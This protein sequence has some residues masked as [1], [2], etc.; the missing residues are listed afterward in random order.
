MPTEI[1]IKINKNKSDNSDFAISPD[2][3]NGIELLKKQFDQISKETKKL[4]EIRNKLVSVLANHGWYLSADIDGQS[5]FKILSLIQNS[6]V[7][8]ATSILSKYYSKNLNKLKNNLTKK[9]PD[10]QS[11]FTEAFKAHKDKKYFSST[12]LFLSQADGICEGNM[13]R[14][15]KIFKEF[16]AKTKSPDMVEF[17]LGQES[18]IDVDTRK[19]D[20]SNYFSDLNRHGVMHGIHIDFGKEI[21]SLKAISLLCFISDFV[22]R[23]KQADKGTGG[24]SGLPQLA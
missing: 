9:H 23:Y 21:N 18:A 5:Y 14:R 11:I 1:Q 15:K 10:R 24:N 19:A 16:I 2:L 22:N 7:G 6:K 13:F 17:I 20:K 4:A 3:F 8:E 12:I